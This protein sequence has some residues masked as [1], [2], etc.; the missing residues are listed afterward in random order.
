MIVFNEIPFH[1]N[2][3]FQYFFRNDSFKKNADERNTAAALPSP[4][5]I[6]EKM[7]LAFFV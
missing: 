7:F 1:L 3:S 2:V 5:L 6:S 4:P